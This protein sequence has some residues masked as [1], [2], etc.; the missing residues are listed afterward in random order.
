MALF[1][2]GQVSS[3]EDLRKLDTQ[4]LEVARVEGIDVTQKLTWPIALGSLLKSLQRW[5]MSAEELE[6]VGPIEC[7]PARD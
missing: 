5:Q 6:E 2:D 4:I 1:I 3:I 7:H